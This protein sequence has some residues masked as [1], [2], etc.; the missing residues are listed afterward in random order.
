M[1]VSVL[2]IHLVLNAMEI[3]TMILNVK[4]LSYV[5]KEMVS[6]LF[7]HVILV[8]IVTVT[9]MITVF[10]QTVNYRML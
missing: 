6:L 3:V 4:V 2:L 5:T 9:T 10:I 7:H 1:M 8:E